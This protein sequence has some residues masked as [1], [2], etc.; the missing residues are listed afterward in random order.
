M[1]DG[2]NDAPKEFYYKGPAYVRPVGRGICIGEDMQQ[3]DDVLGEAL[4]LPLSSGSDIMLEIRAI[5]KPGG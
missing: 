2:Y 4:G 3:L 1:A 5:R